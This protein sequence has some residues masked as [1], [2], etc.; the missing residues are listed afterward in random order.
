MNTAYTA[1]L[2][3]RITAFALAAVTTL[4]LTT[5]IDHLAMPGSADTLAQAGSVPVQQ[6]VVVGS[7]SQA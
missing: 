4:G 5:G 2:S 3:T 1:R 7:R 6:I